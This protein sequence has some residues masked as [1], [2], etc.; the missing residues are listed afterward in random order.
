VC[1]CLNGAFW[2]EKKTVLLATDENDIPYGFF[3]LFWLHPTLSIQIIST[4]NFSDGLHQV[5]LN[6][7]G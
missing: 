2:N 6:P 5:L 7:K 1:P 4:D 3:F